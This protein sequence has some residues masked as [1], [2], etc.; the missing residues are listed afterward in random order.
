MNIKN[1]DELIE[2]ICESVKSTKTDTNKGVNIS[3][4]GLLYDDLQDLVKTFIFHEELKN[5]KISY[6]YNE[7][8]NN[9]ETTTK[10]E[11]TIQWRSD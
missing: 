8:Y 1:Y 9:H 4:D 7:I 2:Y 3:L 10:V 5:Y 11:I 6:N